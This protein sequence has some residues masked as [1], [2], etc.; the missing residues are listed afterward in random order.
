M[1]P[2]LLKVMS[3]LSAG[4][5]FQ[6]SKAKKSWSRMLSWPAVRLSGAF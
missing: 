5:T 2:T 1:R 4:E 6:P 3:I